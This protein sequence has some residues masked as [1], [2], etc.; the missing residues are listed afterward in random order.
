MGTGAKGVDGLSIT[1]DAWIDP[2]KMRSRDWL[3]NSQKANFTDA[4]TVLSLAYQPTR[5]ATWGNFTYDT[6]FD[7]EHVAVYYDDTQ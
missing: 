4:W 3:F 1:T 6:N 2:R 5:N 7:F